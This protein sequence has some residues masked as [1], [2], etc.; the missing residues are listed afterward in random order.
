MKQKLRFFEINLYYIDSTFELNNFSFEL[1]LQKIKLAK[2]KK[3]NWMK[4]K[5]DFLK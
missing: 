4:Q 1:I 2:I 3:F 5:F